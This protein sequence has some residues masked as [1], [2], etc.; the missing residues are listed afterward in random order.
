[1]A[2]A[3]LEPFDKKVYT[4]RQPAMACYKEQSNPLKLTK[5]EFRIEFAAANFVLPTEL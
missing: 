4:L 5:K 2:V 1:V 3:I